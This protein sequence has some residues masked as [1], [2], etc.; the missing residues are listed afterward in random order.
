MHK[1]T[2]ILSGINLYRAG[3]LKIMQDCLAAVSSYNQGEYRIIALVH[4]TKLYKEE[5]GIE[6]IAFPKSRFS[7]FFRIYYEYFA[8]KK[9]SKKYDPYCWLSM[10]DMTPNVKAKI[11]AVYCHNTSP[12]YSCKLKDLFLEY[13]FFMFS[14]F[15]NYLYRINIKKNDYVIVQQDWLRQEFK[16][17]FKINNIIVCLPEHKRNHETEQIKVSESKKRVSFFYPSM[18]RV[19]KNFE[20]VCEA[21]AIL[22][23]REINNLD[24]Y[25]TTQRE[26]NKYSGILTDKYK[27]VASLRFTG[28]LSPSETKE[29]YKQSDCLIF[30]SKLESWGLPISEAKEINMP[31]LLA[32]LPYAK[33]TVGEYDRVK[34]FDPDKPEELADLMESFINGNIVYDK[35]LPFQYEQPF[36]DN[37]HGLFNILLKDKKEQ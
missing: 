11:R 9:L 31:M 6:Y 26:E 23:E 30:P 16:K 19:Y 21:A 28:I 17:R 1:K 24:I 18:P 25:L 22:Q 20:I 12:F 32:N 14:K 15:Y 7:W 34:F 5:N 3:S 2:I 13:P 8:F 37:W 29:Y 27:N 36:T 10:H 4:D 35:T 33:E